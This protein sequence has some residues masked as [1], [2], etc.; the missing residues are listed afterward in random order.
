[1]A[2]NL[3]HLN[4]SQI[5]LLEVLYKFRFSNRQLV[6]QSLGIKA[7]SSLHERLTVLLK[8]GYIGMRL[9]KRLKLVGMPAAY[10]LTPKGMKALQA[11]PDHSSIANSV[12]KA[13]YKDKTIGQSFVTHTMNV[14]KYVN[15]L[16]HQYTGLR[17]FSKREMS[18]YSY[19]PSQ[20]PDA[21][22]SLPIG[23]AQQ[24]KRFFLD[25]IP[26]SLPSYQLVARIARY[27]QFFDEGGWDISGTD[28]PTLLFITE[29][30]ATERRIRRT[31]QMVLQRND[32]EDLGV[33]TTT[34][35]ALI[36]NR[37]VAVWSDLED[38]DELLS[39]AS[40]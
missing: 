17:V 35:S 12:I 24:P 40:R 20:L 10:Y 29:Q 37:E 30:A 25:L 2:T 21:F 8:H 19:F 23:E 16:A 15:I 27:V 36:G 7:G 13:S 33:L 39:L 34:M 22:L 9:E 1:M 6:A 5:E 4:A 32:T 26:D 31:A 38:P 28:V 3:I 14:H 11:V 18:R